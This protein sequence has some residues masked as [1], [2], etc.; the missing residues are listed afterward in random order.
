MTE[1]ETVIMAYKVEIKVSKKGF[2]EKEIS[3]IENIFR[4][5]IAEV[6]TETWEYLRDKLAFLQAKLLVGFGWSEEEVNKI[7]IKDVKVEQ[8]LPK[9]K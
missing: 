3:D 2:E 6:G 5:R 9:R 4:K 8:I 7:R 1:E